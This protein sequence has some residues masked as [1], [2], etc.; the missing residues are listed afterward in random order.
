MQHEI[1]RLSFVGYYPRGEKHKGS[2]IVV[3]LLFLRRGSELLVLLLELLDV[4]GHLRDCLL[5]LLQLLRSRLVVLADTYS[6]T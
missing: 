2:V 6:H 3:C 5:S 1:E 4:I